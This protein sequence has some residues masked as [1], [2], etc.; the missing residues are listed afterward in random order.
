VRFSVLHGSE[1]L[2]ATRYKLVLPTE[3]ELRIELIR[4]QRLLESRMASPAAPKKKAKSPR[5]K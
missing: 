1:Q 2:F 3:D 5:K 4:E